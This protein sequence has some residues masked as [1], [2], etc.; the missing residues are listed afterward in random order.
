MA[1]KKNPYDPRTLEEWQEAA[2]GAELA[3]LIDSC[4]QYG[5]I[6]G[7]PEYDLERCDWILKEAKKRGIVPA[8]HAELVKKSLVGE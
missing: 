4:R 6:E 3:L 5:L 1:K 2:D 8:P 7:G